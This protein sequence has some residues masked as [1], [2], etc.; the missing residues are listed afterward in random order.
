[1]NEVEKQEIDSGTDLISS[2]PSPLIKSEAFLDKMTN[3]WR[4]EFGIPYEIDG[5]LFWGTQMWV[6]VL[7]LLNALQIVKNRLNDEQRAIYLARLNVPQ[8]HLDTLVEMIPVK[9]VKPEVPVEFEVIGYGSGNKS[10]DWLIKPNEERSVLIDVKRRMTD[11]IH[12]MRNTNEPD[13]DEHDHALLFRSV[14]SKFMS[15]DPN[16]QLQG[17][18]IVTDIK[19][20]REKLMTAFNELDA[21]KVHFAILGDWRDDALIVSR[22]NNCIEYLR[23]LFQ[24]SD[25]SRYITN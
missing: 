20:N 7:N 2:I 6:P 21:T 8:K 1:M 3:L 14:E 12:H 23:R 13:N 18:W 16:E 17:V 22:Q 24:I 11:F 19:Q 10:I 15:K 5:S 25:S 9:K 4:Y